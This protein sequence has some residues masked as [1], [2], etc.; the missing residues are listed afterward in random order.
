MKIKL[1]PLF[2]VLFFFSCQNK[3]PKSSSASQSITSSTILKKGAGK[4]IMKSGMKEEKIL[5]IHYYQPDNLQATSEVVFVIPGSGRD[6]DE[7][8]YGWIQKAEAYNLLVISPEYNKQDYPEF[9][10]YNLAGMYK[11]VVLNKERT[12]VESFRISQNTEEWI[13]SDFDKIFNLVKDELHLQ[14]DTYDMFGHSAGGQVLHRLALFHPTNKANRILAA[15]SG[16][17]TLPLDSLEFPYGLKS[18]V[19][20][21]DKINYETNLIVFLGEKDD[22]TET[23]GSLRRSPQADEQGLHRLS[24]GKYFYETARQNAIEN[25]K[26]F[27][28]KL[29]VVP[30]VG[31]EHEKMSAAAADYLY[32]K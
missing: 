26:V 1:L 25:K 4:F 19:Q 20:P 15:N 8:S 6:G 28:W 5:T 18:T 27:N 11:D 17:Y 9:W 31:H 21:S 23:R 24:R 14:T 7:Y 10:N 16:W 3:N 13:F 30:N 12:R 32:K 29:E 22:A 2:L